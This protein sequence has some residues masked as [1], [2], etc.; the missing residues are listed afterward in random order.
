MGPDAN[1]CAAIGYDD[2]RSLCTIRPEGAPDREACENWRVGKAKDTGRP[3]P[4]WTKGDGSYCTGAASGCENHPNP[5]SLFTYVSGTYVVT[6]ENGA[7][8]TVSY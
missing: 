5:Y 4:T 6:A 8:C 7:D 2:G 1:Y 3:G